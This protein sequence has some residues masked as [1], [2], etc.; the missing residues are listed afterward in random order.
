MRLSLLKSAEYPDYTAEQG[1]QEFIYALFVHT[2][3]WY[4]SRLI[5]EAWDLNDPLIALPVSVRSPFPVFDFSECD[6]FLDVLKK[7]EDGED[8]IL[9]LHEKKGGKRLIKIGLPSVCTAWIVVDLLEE[10]MEASWH[11]GSMI[12]YCL[13][14]FEV[15]TFRVRW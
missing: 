6:A 7:S 10:P 9:R 13:H 3:P 5:K 15:V 12:E 2:E 4:E 8:V 1:E 14:P 11:E